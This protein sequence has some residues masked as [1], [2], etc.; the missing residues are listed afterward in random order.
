MFPTDFEFIFLYT[1]YLV[2]FLYL[3]ISLLVTKKKYYKINLAFYF[4]YASSMIYVFLDE[5][6]FKG[7]GSLVVLFYGALPI[8]TQIMILLIDKSIKF[9]RN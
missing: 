9:I 6:N 8:F 1:S 4:V 7:G 2:L 5:D 3:I